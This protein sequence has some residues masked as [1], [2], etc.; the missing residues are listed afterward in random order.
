MI[1]PSFR[2]TRMPHFSG[3]LST[4][5]PYIIYPLNPTDV[6][7]LHIGGPRATRPRGLHLLLR[8]LQPGRTRSTHSPTQVLQKTNLGKTF[9]QYVTANYS[10]YTFV[11]DGFVFLVMVESAV[12][13]VPYSMKHVSRPT[14]SR[15]SRRP[16]SLDMTRPSVVRRWGTP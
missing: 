12:P 6:H 4:L 2:R 8:Q 16:S 13:T 9:G 7:D 11:K 5:I 10:F 3:G 14:S 15:R 1:N